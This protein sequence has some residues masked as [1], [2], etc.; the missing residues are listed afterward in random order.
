MAKTT[1][2]AARRKRKGKQAPGR[3]G[4][5]LRSARAIE[6]TLA[7]LAHEIRTPLT[8]ILALSELLATSEVGE[9]ERGWAAAIKSTAEHLTMLTSLVIDAVRANAKGIVLRPDLVYPR[10]IAE[11]LAASLTAR[12]ETKG[13]KAE[14]FIADDLPE[15]AIADALRLRAIGFLQQTELLAR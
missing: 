11:A 15:T 12:A 8:G 2:S 1:T 4:R 10:R 13:L 7:E 6:A 14:V 5:K 3:P 9:R